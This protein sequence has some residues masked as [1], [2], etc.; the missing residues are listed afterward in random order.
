[1]SSGVG[2][3]RGSDLTLLWLWCRL[4][5]TG[6]IRPL[7][8]EPPYAAGVALEKAKRQ[9]I[10]QSINKRTLSQWRAFQKGGPYGLEHKDWEERMELRGELWRGE[11][12]EGCSGQRHGLGRAW[13]CSGPDGYE[14]LRGQC[15]S[16]HMV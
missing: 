8:W 16:G 12:R 4:V 1:M 11:E 6:P 7:A 13:W 3:R 15:G 2:C 14:G 9:S 5:A 10:N